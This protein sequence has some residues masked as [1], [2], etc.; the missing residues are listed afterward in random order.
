[1]RL[2]LNGEVNFKTYKY[3]YLFEILFL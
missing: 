3:Y 2:F 1:M